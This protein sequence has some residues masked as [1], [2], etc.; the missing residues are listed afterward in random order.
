VELPRTIT[1]ALFAGLFLACAGGRPS[2]D[3]SSFGPEDGMLLYRAI[4]PSSHATTWRVGEAKEAAIWLGDTTGGWARHGDTAR[5]CGQ[6]RDDPRQRRPACVDITAGPCARSSPAAPPI[7]EGDRVWVP[8]SRGRILEVEVSRNIAAIDQRLGWRVFEEGAWRSLTLE[9]TPR[10]LDETDSYWIDRDDG[11]VWTRGGEPVAFEGPEI[12][13][14]VPGASGD[15]LLVQTREGLLRW[16]PGQAPEPAFAHGDHTHPTLATWSPDTTKLLFFSTQG[17]VEHA[18]PMGSPYTE[19]DPHAV[20]LASGGI[21]RIGRLDARFHTDHV[22]W[23][24]RS[25]TEC[26][27][28]PR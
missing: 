15:E 26:I 7:E 12:E 1:V 18:P 5:W 13:A 11:L 2:Y 16:T 22:L 24:S 3:H 4:T 20:D 19:S 25:L 28:E 6:V 23:L 21:G 27:A 17:G 14:L 9:P 8:S 10:Y